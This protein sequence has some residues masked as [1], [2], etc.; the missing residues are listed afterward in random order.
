MENQIEKLKQEIEETNQRMVEIKQ[1]QASLIAAINF[2]I[3]EYP[4]DRASQYLD[5]VMGN[6]FSK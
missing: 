2:A 4:S 3:A 1:R 6:I 5:S